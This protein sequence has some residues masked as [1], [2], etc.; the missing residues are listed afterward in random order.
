M[1]FIEVCAS[2]IDQ[3]LSNSHTSPPASLCP[4]RH[5]CLHLYIRTHTVTN[6]SH[7]SPTR[8]HFLCALAVCCLTASRVANRILQP[9]ARHLY[10]RVAVGVDALNAGAAEALSAMRFVDAFATVRLTIEAARVA[11][12]CCTPGDVA[13]RARVDDSKSIGSRFGVYD[14]ESAITCNNNIAGEHT[15][16]FCLKSHRCQIAVV[17][18]HHTASVPSRFQARS[19]CER[20]SAALAHQ[21]APD[22]STA[23]VPPQMLHQTQRPSS[24][25]AVMSPHPPAFHQAVSPCRCEMLSCC[26]SCPLDGDSAAAAA[27]R[28]D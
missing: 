23:P 24:H 3:R 10:S 12:T 26:D 11:S 4:T 20:A 14:R 9:L 8:S 2:L 17:A 5:H 7:S 19:S 16:S 28:R 21:T 6:N 27:Q 25:V 13:D 18:A 22:S 15:P 1:C